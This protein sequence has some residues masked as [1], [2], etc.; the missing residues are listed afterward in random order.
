M[1]E[2]SSLDQNKDGMISEETKWNGAA[3]VGV[4]QKTSTLTAL[5]MHDSYRGN[6]IRGEAL[7]VADE[8]ELIES[9]NESSE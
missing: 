6:Q 7:L 8:T 1:L 5:L 2:F 9:E 4:Y 3:S